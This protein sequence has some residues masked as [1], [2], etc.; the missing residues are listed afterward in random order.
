MQLG[1]LGARRDHAPGRD[2]V[3][4]LA[5]QSPARLAI[6]VFS[7]VVA[8][9]TALLSMPAATAEGHRAPFVDALFTAVST[10]CVT[11][12]VTVPTGT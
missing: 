7:G 11:G 9:F 5:R 6:G 2:L 12:L 8:L 3:D 10:V 4:R 1:T